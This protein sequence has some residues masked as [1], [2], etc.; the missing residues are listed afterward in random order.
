[1]IKICFI[2]TADDC[3][4][5]MFVPSQLNITFFGSNFFSLTSLAGK[6]SIFRQNTHNANSSWKYCSQEEMG[7][8]IKK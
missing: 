7:G 6:F 2:V 4:R 5:G 8:L 1:M 3:T